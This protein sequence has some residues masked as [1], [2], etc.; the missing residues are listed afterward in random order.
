[1]GEAKCPHCGSTNVFGMSRI[2]GYFSIIENWN[3]GKRAEFKLRQ[4]GN[5]RV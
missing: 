4:K 1:M 5:Y 2:V 3:K